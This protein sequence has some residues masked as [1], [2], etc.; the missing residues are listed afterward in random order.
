MAHHVNT[1]NCFVAIVTLYKSS[2]C[3][4]A[5][6]AAVSSR[7]AAVAPEHAGSVIQEHMQV[8]HSSQAMLVNDKLAHARMSVTRIIITRIIIT[9]HHTH[10]RHETTH[11]RRGTTS[12][13]PFTHME[14]VTS[15]GTPAG[16]S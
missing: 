5:Y 10:T 7:T 3:I 1:I 2:R 4:R 9:H 12:V 15:N 8:T 16:C 6:K 11:T 14:N 13:L